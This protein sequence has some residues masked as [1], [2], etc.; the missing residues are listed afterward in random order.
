MISRFMENATRIIGRIREMPIFYWG[1]ALLAGTG[2]GAVVTVGAL[3]A[4]R[5]A[6]KGFCYPLNVLVHTQKPGFLG[7]TTLEGAAIVLLSAAFWG[8]IFA[9]IAAAAPVLRAAGWGQAVLLGFSWGVVYHVLVG[10]TVSPLATT[11][12]PHQHPIA[13]AVIDTLYG[14]GVSLALYGTFTRR[15]L[16]ITFA[17]EPA[18]AGTRRHR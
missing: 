6:D 11:F 14:V 5:L 3:I 8:L 15:A 12:Y 7:A 18:P 1:K 9:G 2:S 16:S 17:P 4:S 13:V 10:L